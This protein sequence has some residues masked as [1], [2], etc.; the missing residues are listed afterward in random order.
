MTPRWL[1]APALLGALAADTLAADLPL[2][3]GSALSALYEVDGSMTRLTVKLI[4]GSGKSFQWMATLDDP[5]AVA[6][7]T[8]VN[9]GLYPVDDDP[10]DEAAGGVLAVEFTPVPGRFRGATALD[11]EAPESS[12]IRIWLADDGAPPIDIPLANPGNGSSQTI[13]TDVANVDCVEFHFGGSA[14]L[15]ELRVC[16]P[17]EDNA[18]QD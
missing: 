18:P 4:N 12:C 13:E 6:S 11:V 2:K 1:L 8:W 3:P 14:A 5:G 16:P 15:A 9:L 7:P 10:D 17:A